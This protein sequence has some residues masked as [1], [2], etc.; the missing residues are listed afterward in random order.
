MK[1]LSIREEKTSKR[2]G[3][4]WPFAWRYLL[5]VV[6]LTGLL[7]LL[8]LLV[9]S[10]GHNGSDEDNWYEPIDSADWDTSQDS[11]DWPVN[12]YED[13]PQLPDPVDNHP[14]QPDD[15]NIVEQPEDGRTVVNNRLN[16]IL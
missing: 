6:V 14:Q 8:L 7:L 13:V 15:D 4:F 11:A 10:C 3:G 9:R 2:G 16:L 1:K 12:P 5:F